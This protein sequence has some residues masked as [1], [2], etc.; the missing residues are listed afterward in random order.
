MASF[1]QHGKL[2]YFRFIDASGKQVER[3]GHW[4]KKTAQA[5]ARKAEDE[6]AKVRS[7]LIDPKDVAYRNHE[8]APLAHHLDA[9]HRDM[10]AKGKTAKHAD[11]SRDRAAKLIAMVKGVS[12][13]KLVPG[14]KAD[15][16]AQAARLL[17]TTLEQA[18]FSDLT[19]ET[20]Q[21]ALA[22]LKDEG[23]SAQTA[24]HFRAA[25]RAYLK[26]CHRRGR[27]RTVSSEGVGAFNVS[28]DLRHV[29][30]SLTDDELAL[31]IDSAESGPGRLCTSGPVRSIAYRT[32]AFT[33]FRVDELRSLTPESFHL[34]SPRPFITLTAASAKNRKP[35]D[36]PVPS[37]LVGPLK[38]WL[39][40]KDPGESV[41]PLHHDTGK[42]IR[43]DLGAI[44][45]AYK[46]DD[47]IADFHSLRAYYISALVR[48]GASISEVHKLARYAKPETTLNHYAKVSAHDLCG[49]VE[50]LPNPSRTASEPEKLAAT[51]T[52]G[53]PISKL[54][55]LHFPY[56]DDQ[57]R[58]DKS[59]PD[60]MRARNDERVASTPE[61]D[62]SLQDKASDDQ[63]RRVAGIDGEEVPE[64]PPGFEPGN[65]GFADR[66]LTTWLRS[67][68]P[69]S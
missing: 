60:E 21:A 17:A 36:Q 29:R 41:F 18:L 43:A 67:Q 32:A 51:G 65:N 54:G 57:T 55:S 2:W 40:D 27:V 9:W 37:S 3:K 62:S 7:G 38:A 4:D 42:A 35:T 26:C 33:G 48:S 5:M 19:S 64:A 63:S 52:T 10:L 8:A 56:G 30:R 34:E 20:I 6:V 14:R 31:L 66:R 50:T 53:Q 47:G 23:R 44:G 22:R 39:A 13:D 45:I 1:R 15:A 12:L 49:A 69:K 59:S 46:T 58:V 24:N 68:Q 61:I 11:L 16:M 28:E 25:I